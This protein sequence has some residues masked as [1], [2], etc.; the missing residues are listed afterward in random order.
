MNVSKPRPSDH[1]TLFLFV[2]GGIA[3][4]EIKCLKDTLNKMRPAQKV[5]SKYLNFYFFCKFTAV[6]GHLRLQLSL[7]TCDYTPKPFF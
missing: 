3:W 2:V 7:V 4:H 6:L 5:T 1:P